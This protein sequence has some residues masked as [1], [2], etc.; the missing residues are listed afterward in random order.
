MPI[1]I[2]GLIKGMTSNDVYNFKMQPLIRRI[3]E[4]LEDVYKK[5]YKKF[6]LNTHPFIA[7]YLE[8]GYPSIRLKWYFKYQKWIKIIPR[9]AYKYLE[10]HFTQEDGKIIKL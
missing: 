7:A 2:W 1:T 3:S 10:Y 5:G 9:D 8:R 6:N 4:E